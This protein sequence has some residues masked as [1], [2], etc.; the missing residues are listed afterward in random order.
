MSSSTIKDSYDVRAAVN[1]N[2]QAI[3]RY[4]H[5][6]DAAKQVFGWAIDNADLQDRF[7]VEQLRHVVQLEVARVV[8]AEPP[9]PIAHAGYN[10]ERK[11]RAPVPMEVAQSFHRAHFAAAG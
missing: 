2:K 4:P 8:S 7:V 10:R 5:R 3:G 6:S 1:N 11:V 9:T